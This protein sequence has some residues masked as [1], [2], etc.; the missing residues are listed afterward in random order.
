MATAVTT[1]VVES[2]V[3]IH[4]QKHVAWIHYVESINNIVERV[5]KWLLCLSRLVDMLSRSEKERVSN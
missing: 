5:E 2:P 4:W 3:S 1:T